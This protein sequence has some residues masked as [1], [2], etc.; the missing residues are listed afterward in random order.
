[1]E[2]ADLRN[3]LAEYVNDHATLMDNTMQLLHKTCNNAA[4]PIDQIVNKYVT[5]LVSSI[6][7]GNGIRALIEQAIDRQVELIITKDD[8]AE[9]AIKECLSEMKIDC[10]EVVQTAIENSLDQV[11]IKFGRR[12]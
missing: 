9:E 11:E 6:L 7:E 4:Q 2:A 1:M 8:F 12:Y 10:E 5:D 3:Y